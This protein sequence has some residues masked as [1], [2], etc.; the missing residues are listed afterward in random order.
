M[1]VPPF[2]DCKNSDDCDFAATIAFSRCKEPRYY[3]CNNSRNTRDHALFHHVDGD[4]VELDEFGAT[5]PRIFSIG[6]GQ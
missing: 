4:L 1:R 6:F 5:K 2:K 3:E